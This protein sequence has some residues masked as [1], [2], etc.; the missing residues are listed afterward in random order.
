MSSFE[1]DGDSRLNDSKG[2]YIGDSPV[3]A[4]QGD[5]PYIFISYAHDDADLVHP[6]IERFYL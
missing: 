1:N 2:K 6:E 3:P 5:E 4:Y